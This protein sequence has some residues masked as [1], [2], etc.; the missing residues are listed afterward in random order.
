MVR[1]G[2][3]LSVIAQRY[4]KTTS[5][6]KAYNQL[7]STSL[8]VG[9]KIKIPITAKRFTK[10]KVRSGESLSVIAQRYGTTT[11]ALKV[12]NK[13]PSNS[14]LIGQVL[15]IPVTKKFSLDHYR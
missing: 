11:E 5:E 7:H 15:T 14:L 13:L 10:H 8:Q 12:F 3:S 6:L 4:G 2:E 1:R 9:Q